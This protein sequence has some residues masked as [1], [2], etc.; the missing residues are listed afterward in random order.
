ML[1]ENGQRIQR[2][3]SRHLCLK[4]DPLS[5]P[6]SN[7]QQGTKQGSADSVSFREAKTNKIV[8]M[9]L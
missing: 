3:K 1:S 5:Q 8:D 7:R 9:I 2:G 6:H 4:D